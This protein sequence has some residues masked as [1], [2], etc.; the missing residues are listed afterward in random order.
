MIVKCIYQD[1]VA[2]RRIIMQ[3]IPNLCFSQIDIIKNTSNLD[4]DHIKKR[5]T[6]IPVRGGKLFGRKELEKIID[7]NIE[8]VVNHVFENINDDNVPVLTMKCYKKYNSD[9]DGIIQ[10]VSTNDCQFSLNGRELKNPYSNGSFKIVDL[11]YDKSN[12]QELEFIASTELNIPYFSSIFSC[13]ETPLLKLD[14]GKRKQE[15]SLQTRNNE[16]SEKDII[17]VSKK[18]LLMKLKYI[19]KK[20]EDVKDRIG[21]IEFHNDLYTIPNLLSFYLNKSVDIS[22][23]TNNYSNMLDNKGY[24]SYVIKDT[25]SKGISQIIKENVLESISWNV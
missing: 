10:S 5:I 3:S 8:L 18:I 19:V 11:K 14:Y 25:S 9:V 24:V 12:K 6:N 7:S 15:L 23:A 16:F 2:L 4:N 13:C 1:V 20:L 17:L 21:K 22:M